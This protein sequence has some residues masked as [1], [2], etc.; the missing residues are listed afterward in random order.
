MLGFCQLVGKA[1]AMLADGR[2]FRII[3][4]EL[5]SAPRESGRLFMA[6]G[7]PL[8]FCQ[9]AFLG[10]ESFGMRTASLDERFPMNMFRIVVL[11]VGDSTKFPHMR[12][13]L[14]LVG[15]SGRGLPLLDKYSLR[16]IN[17]M[18]A[19]GQLRH[20]QQLQS[21]TRNPLFVARTRHTLSHRSDA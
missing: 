7:C 15:P 12:K 10:K 21:F 5:I 1:Q 2:A 4:P 14:F 13:A 9:L 8:R 18:R 6:G 16:L 11:E 19:G 17:N 3:S 20:V